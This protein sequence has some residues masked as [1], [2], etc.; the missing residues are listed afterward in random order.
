M[1]SSIKDLFSTEEILHGILHFL[2]S[3]KIRQ[4]ALVCLRV[5]VYLS[6]TVCL[7]IC[8]CVCVSNQNLNKDFEL[9]L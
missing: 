1:E 5:I 9:K 7:C 8:D 2:C 3:K 4:S 6:V